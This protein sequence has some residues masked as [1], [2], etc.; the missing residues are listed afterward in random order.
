MLWCISKLPWRIF[1]VFSTCL[2]IVTYYIIRY[3]KKIVTENLTLVFPR[4]SKQE[5]YGIRKAFYRHMCD[6]FLEMIKT[7]SISE[8][9]LSKRFKITN[10]EVL[11]TIESKNKS[12]IVLIAHYASYEWSIAV[13]FLGGFPIVGVYKKLKNEH[14]DKLIHQIRGRFD[15]RLISKHNT[16][17]AITRDKVQ[18]KLCAYGFVTDQSPRLKNSMYW[19]NFMDIK[20]P[21]YLGGEKIA[22]RMNLPVVYLKVDKA[23]RGYYEAEF[24]LITENP[25]ECDDYYITK[26]YLKLVESQIRTKPEHYLWTHKRWKYRNAKIPK[27]AIVD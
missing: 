9:E 27:G 5:I 15:A 10:P 25:E 2:Y 4:K 22:K 6:M 26:E 14:F 8:K 13:Q 3:R 7:M 17:R 20:V 18:G 1:Y 11:T 16:I 19:T 12:I 21:I 24:I 23:K